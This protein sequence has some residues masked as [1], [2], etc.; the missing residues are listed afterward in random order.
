VFPKDRRPEDSLGSAE[1][2]RRRLLGDVER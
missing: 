1:L 2:F